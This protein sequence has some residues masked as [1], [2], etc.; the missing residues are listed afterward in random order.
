MFALDLT[1]SGMVEVQ[2][3]FAKDPPA[4]GQK[5][6]V[7]L[8]CEGQVTGFLQNVVVELLVDGRPGC[9]EVGGSHVTEG[10]VIH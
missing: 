5:D 1:G 9:G 10:C 8:E 7:V 4:E 2:E 6:W 3:V